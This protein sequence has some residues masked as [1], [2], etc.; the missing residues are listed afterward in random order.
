MGGSVLVRGM[1]L[2]NVMTSKKVCRTRPAVCSKKL[3]SLFMKSG[4]FSG[5]THEQVWVELLTEYHP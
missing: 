1:L 5:E 2:S 3:G 4:L